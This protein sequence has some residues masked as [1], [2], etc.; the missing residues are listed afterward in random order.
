MKNLVAVC[1]TFLSFICATNTALAQSVETRELYEIQLN[2]KAYLR[3]PIQ[4]FGVIE[5]TD[6]YTGEFKKASKTHYSFLLRG[7]GRTDFFV[8]MKRGGKADELVTKFA[9]M[10][11][12]SKLDGVFII[13]LNYVD[14]VAEVLDFTLG[15]KKPEKPKPAPKNPATTVTSE[16]DRF[17]DETTVAGIA[18]LIDCQDRANLPLHFDFGAIIK[19]SG[20]EVVSPDDITLTLRLLKYDIGSNPDFIFF[21]DGKRLLLGKGVSEA[22]VWNVEGIRMSETISSVKINLVAFKAIANA[23]SVEAKVGELEFAQPY[24]DAAAVNRIIPVFREML[25]KIHPK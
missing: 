16:Y 8:Y 13:Q 7:S 15:A 3:R 23:N 14:E 2:Q 4:V 6:Y 18:H 9:G 21:V 20:K 11:Q 19:F 1:L 10:P 22:K 5:L 12:Y 24:V 17:R 25:A